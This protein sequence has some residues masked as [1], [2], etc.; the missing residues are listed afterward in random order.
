MADRWVGKLVT[1]LGNEFGE[2]GTPA[3]CYLIGGLSGV[4]R[5]HFSVDTAEFA[6][7]GGYLYVRASGKRCRFALVG[8]PF[9]GAASVVDLP[10]RRWEPEDLSP[11]DDVFAEGGGVELLGRPFA[12]LAIRLSCTR[13]APDVGTLSL[14]LW[15]EVE[16][17][18]TGE[19][20][21]VDGVLR[22][23]EVALGDD[24]W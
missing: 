1:L 11:S 23:R 16:D 15:C 12:V 24:G 3:G 10:G 8:A 14:E 7:C 5:A 18:E 4:P 13:Y 19:S 21:E 22:C 9:P 17:E 6:L 2:E 20:G